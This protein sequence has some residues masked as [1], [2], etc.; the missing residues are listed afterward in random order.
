MNTPIPCIKQKSR[1]RGLA[2]VET[3]IIL[4][5]LLL[6]MLATAELGRAFYLSNSLAKMVRDGTRYMSANATKG[7]TGII[8]PTDADYINAEIVTKNLIVYGTPGG[9]GNVLL[10]GF[11]AADVT[12]SIV[13][14]IHIQVNAVYNFTPIFATIPTFGLSAQ[15]IQI[16]FPLTATLIMR[17][18]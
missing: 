5:I 4:P 18:L 3:V 7:D 13:D 2:A 17:A 12:V 9:T 1:Q 11:S 10:P 6:L 15:N 14:P 8:D 16:N